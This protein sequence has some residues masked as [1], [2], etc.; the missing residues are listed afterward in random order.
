M[1]RDDVLRA[2]CVVALICGSNDAFAQTPGATSDCAAPPGMEPFEFEFEGNVLRG[3]IDRPEKTGLSPLV[4]LIPGSGRTDVMRERRFFGGALADHGV[5]T[6]IWDKPGSGCSDGTYSDVP[7]LYSRVDEVLAAIAEVERH[8]GID[9]DRIGVLG[10]SQGAWV[11][12]MAVARNRDIAFM[13]T[14]SAPARD[15]TRQA[16]HLVRSNMALEGY[17]GEEIGALAGS[18]ERAQVMMMAGASYEDYAAAM[19]PIA[20]HP[21]LRELAGEGGSVMWSREDYAKFQRSGDLLISADSFLRVIR[22]PT[23]V[24]FGDKDTLVDW[25]QSMDTYRQAFAHNGNQ[26][27]SIRVFKN[28]NHLLC[29]AE[30]GSIKEIANRRGC[31]RPEDFG[32]TLAGWLERHGFVR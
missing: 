17:S 15:M 27:L 9:P 8:P 29:I 4:V 28:A 14:M 5:A 24:I 10:Q 32:E 13:I 11:A 7:S 18:Y 21:F 12:P 20:D 31:R 19:A 1:K 2:I 22:V 23:L 30:T 26:D 6:V 3:F 25:Q 16:D